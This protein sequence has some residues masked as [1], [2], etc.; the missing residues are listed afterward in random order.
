VECQTI[1]EHN[2][3]FIFFE[4][5]QRINILD[6]INRIDRINLVAF[7]QKT[8]TARAAGIIL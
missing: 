2:S 4:V 6:R 5:A 3:G 8:R 1:A 7:G